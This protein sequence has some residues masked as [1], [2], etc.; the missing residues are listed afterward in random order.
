MF[1]WQQY[2]R[3]FYSI[4]CLLMLVGLYYA[5]IC[6]PCVDCMSHAADKFIPWT[7]ARRTAS[8]RFASFKH[9]HKILFSD[10]F[11]SCV[12]FLLTRI[13]QQQQPVWGVGVKNSGFI[14]KFY[15]ELIGMNRDGCSTSNITINILSNPLKNFKAISK[16]FPIGIC[17]FSHFNSSFNKIQSS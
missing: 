14:R 13:K 8:H 4:D 2:L 3:Q 6:K 7:M 11:T 5:S 12:R 9:I 16:T 15:W 10:L 1:I 17:F